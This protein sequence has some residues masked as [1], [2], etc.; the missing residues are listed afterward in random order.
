MLSI[1][2]V[3]F[4]MQNQKKLPEIHFDHFLAFEFSFCHCYTWNVKMLSDKNQIKI[5][6]LFPFN[7]FHIVFHFCVTKYLSAL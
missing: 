4:V 2:G 3:Y 7:V 5:P 1:L 6:T